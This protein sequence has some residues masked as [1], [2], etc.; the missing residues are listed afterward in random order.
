MNDY[1]EINKFLEFDSLHLIDCLV[2]TDSS[3]LLLDPF[4]LKMN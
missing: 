4:E 2:Q 1:M 3:S